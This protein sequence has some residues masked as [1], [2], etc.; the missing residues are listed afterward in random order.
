VTGLKNG[1]IS[2]AQYVTAAKN[3]W[4]ALGNKTSSS[5]Q[6]SQVCPGTGQA[7]GQ[8]GVGTDLKSQQDFYIK[9]QSMFSAGDQHG[10]APLLWS[11]IALLRTD[12]PGMR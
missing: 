9:L 7:S 2:G 12:C 4:T 3:G 10:Q 1:W 5:G 8:S 11:A 6:L